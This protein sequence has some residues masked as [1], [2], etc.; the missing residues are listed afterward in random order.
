[1]CGKRV[2]SDHVLPPSVERVMRC[3]LNS[4]WQ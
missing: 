4:A 3:G 2:G 1:V